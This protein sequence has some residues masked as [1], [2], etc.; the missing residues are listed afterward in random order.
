M[1]LGLVDLLG[2]IGWVTVVKKVAA[3]S[4][5]PKRGYCCCL[6]PVWTHLHSHP[7]VPTG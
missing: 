4:F 1:A 5:S 7:A 3:C 2:T 6:G